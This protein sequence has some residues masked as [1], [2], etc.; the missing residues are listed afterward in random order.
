MKPKGT[1]NSN[2]IAVI[3]AGPVGCTLAA[4]LAQGGENVILC[5]IN[6]DL[7]KPALDPGITIEGAARLQQK[8]SATCIHVD[9]LAQ[10]RPAVI[11]LTVKASAIPLI[12]SA[13]ETFY[14]K[15]IVVVSWQNGIDTEAEVA[16]VLGRAPVM[17]AVVNYGCWLIQPGRVR[18]VFHHPPHYLQELAP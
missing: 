8:V 14:R 7:I 13:I 9:E 17:R 10:Y 5:D 2:T 3:G 11:F 12:A 4:F 18:L 15:G 6:P 1:L 16:R